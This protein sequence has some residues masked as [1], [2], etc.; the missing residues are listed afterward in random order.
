[1]YIPVCKYQNRS[2]TQRV[3]RRSQLPRPKSPDDGG[4]TREYNPNSC[5]FKKDNA[6]WLNTQLPLRVSVWWEI[7]TQST[8]DWKW[9]QWREQEDEG[10][11]V[12]VDF[13]GR[14]SRGGCSG[15]GGG[16]GGVRLCTEKVVAEAWHVAVAM[17]VVG[18]SRAENDR[19]FKAILQAEEA[20]VG[21]G[22]GNSG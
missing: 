16:G 4:C 22:G 10:R 6:Y 8:Y 20:V 21:G 17:E 15:G 7:E 18:D 13:W 1:M 11:G 14:D 2:L 9:G 19:R 12:G 5:K 3:S